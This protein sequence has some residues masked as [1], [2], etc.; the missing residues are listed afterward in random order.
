MKNDET[1]FYRC[2]YCNK[3][4]EV[5]NGKIKDKC[6]DCK[7]KYEENTYSS[8]GKLFILLGLFLGIVFSIFSPNGLGFS[9][10]IC[11]FVGGIVSSIL[12]FIASSIIERLNVI[13][14][15]P[16]RYNDDNN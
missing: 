14:N 1:F 13:A 15:P 2:K 10:F 7:E 6:P 4:V 11:F 8:I 16:K 3:L 9:A 12:F 5:N